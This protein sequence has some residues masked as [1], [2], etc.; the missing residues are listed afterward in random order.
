MLVEQNVAASLGLAEH[1]YVLENGRIVMH[2]RG[3]ELLHDD[4]VRRRTSAFSG[5]GGRRAIVGERVEHVKVDVPLA[6]C[7]SVSSASFLTTN[8]WRGYFFLGQALAG[9][10]L[11]RLRI[12]DV[13]GGHD[14]RDHLLALL[15][16]GRAHDRGF[17]HGRE[18]EQHVLD[19]ARV[20]VVS[21]ANDQVLFPV[22][23]EQVA[24]G[25]R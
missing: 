10:G 1:A 3:E 11:H 22:D 15:L 24:L 9:E 23:Q 8:T 6:S 7:Q 17:G 12:D 25:S 2:G 13:G 14:E 16:V 4:R 21:R 18:R 5:S 19:L 20:N